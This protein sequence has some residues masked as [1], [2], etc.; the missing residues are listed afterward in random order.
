MRPYSTP[1]RICSL[2]H[3]EIFLCLN[4]A[5]IVVP[6]E[7][8][9]DLETRVVNANYPRNN[10]RF[11]VLTLQEEG[12]FSEASTWQKSGAVKI[13]APFN[14]SSLDHISPGFGLKRYGVVMRLAHGIKQRDRL[15]EQVKGR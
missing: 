6:G 11:P 14:R 2:L 15:R 13:P 8:G 3:C 12:R 9:Q 10:P 7:E 1:L 5:A 4:V